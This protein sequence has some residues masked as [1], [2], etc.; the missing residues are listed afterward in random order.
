LVTKCS[1]ANDER[2]FVFRG[3]LWLRKN[4]G[5]TWATLVLREIMVLTGILDGIGV[6]RRRLRKCGS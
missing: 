5:S 2:C 1:T 6:F 4:S 3:M